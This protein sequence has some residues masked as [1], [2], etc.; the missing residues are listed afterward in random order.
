MASKKIGD[1]KKFVYDDDL[2]ALVDSE[3][4]VVRETYVLE[5]LSFVSGTGTVPTA[6]VK[7]RK[8]KE[9]KTDAGVGDGAVD[10]VLKTI[11]RMTGKRGKLLDYQ[12][13]ATTSGKDAVGEVTVK[14][15]FGGAEPIIGR[16]AST[17]VVE[18]SAKA[19]L[20]AINRALTNG[21]RHKTVRG[22]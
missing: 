5:H 19:Y 4:S 14:V 3:A 1:A 10:A 17:D 12:V 21:K 18:A 9:I 11:D 13:R 8:N 6:T 2:V 20:N 7:L 16:G 22:V 15:D